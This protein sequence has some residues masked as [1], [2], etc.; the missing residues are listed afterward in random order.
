MSRSNAIYV[1]PI[2]DGATKAHQDY[3]IAADQANEF[4]ALFPPTPDVTAT[5]LNAVAGAASEAASGLA[6]AEETQ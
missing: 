3:A 2:I 4:A 5:G 1:K 6:K